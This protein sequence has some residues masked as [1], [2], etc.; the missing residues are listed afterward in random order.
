MFLSEK[1]L[2]RMMHAYLGVALGVA[3]CLLY[4]SYLVITES[5]SD[6]TSITKP[7]F[8][9]TPIAPIQNKSN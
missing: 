9:L 2:R 5:M 7:T 8:V 4:A 1:V 3:I 6:K